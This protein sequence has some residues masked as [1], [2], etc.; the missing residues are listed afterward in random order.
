MTRTR[1]PK[2]SRFAPLVAL[3]LC[4]CSALA[5]NSCTFER[6]D[7]EGVIYYD[8]EFPFLEDNMLKNVFPEEMKL[9]FKDDKMYGEVR[10]LGGI[11]TTS[12][13][14]DNEEKTITQ[15]LKNYSDY[16]CSTLDEPN[17]R[18]SLSGHPGIRYEATERTELVAGYMCKVTIAHFLTDSV[19]PITLLHTDEID[20]ES[21]NWY[22]PFH[23]IS[24][25]LLGYEV[26][27]FGMRM[28]LRANTVAKK[29]VEDQ[30]LV[31][32]DKYQEIPVQELSEMMSGMLTDFID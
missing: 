5:F 6:P 3:A 10:S 17:V 11:V 18:Q 4:L 8:L 29:V 9:Y 31:K 19:P 28:K 32:R 27:Q 23:E 13:I 16:Y 12:F 7:A 21:P 14:A 2:G 15:M 20:I 1:Q 30:M 26:E 24:E 22:S 25:V